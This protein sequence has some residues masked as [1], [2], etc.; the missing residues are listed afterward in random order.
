M[1]LPDFLRRCSRRL[2]ADAVCYPLLARFAH[3]R[4]ATTEQEVQTAYERLAALSPD[5]GRSCLHSN[6][7]T[8][9]TEFDLQIIIP[10][11]NAENFIDECIGSV[12]S[13]QT[14][15]SV[16]T[17]IIN[18]GSTDTTRQ[19]LNAYE[20][21]SDIVI[22]DQP[23]GGFSKARNTGISTLCARYVMFLDA[24]DRL[25]P[26]SVETLMDKATASDSDIVEGGY[27]RFRNEGTVICR[28]RHRECAGTDWSTLYGYPWGKVYKAGLFADVQF[29][30]GYWF[31]DTLLPYAVYPRA[32][33][34][35]T[36]PNT[37]YHY[38]DHADGI[39]RRS[40]GL[41][42]NIDALWVTKRMLEDSERLGICR[43][44]R[45]YH[46]VLKDFLTNFSRI[47]GLRSSRTDKDL[48]I[49]TTDLMHR[50][51]P[52]I[53]TSDTALRPLELALRASDFQAYR[54]YCLFHSF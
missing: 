5:K 49:V 28:Y 2:H 17:V 32:T 4:I 1:Q 53:R 30:E 42:R 48:F 40:A 51:F 6:R 13:Q 19:R 34:V 33:R 16:L 39:S 8:R 9:P 41:P 29:P 7:L 38:R 3:G 35:T 18:D 50:Y 12:L 24:D 21:M 10:V 31:E 43:D 26:G 11:Y 44:E 46:T 22:I 45:F 27:L 20:G 14:H 25:V 15:Y 37:V 54:L 36:I 23:N 47:R 52:D